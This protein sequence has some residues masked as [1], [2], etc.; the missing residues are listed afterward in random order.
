MKEKFLEKAKTLKI[1][2]GEKYNFCTC[3]RS[4]N[5][6]YCDNEHRK[7]N[8]ERRTNYKSL[9]IIPKSDVEIEVYCSNWD[10]ESSRE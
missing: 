9:K 10:S 5:I 1:I 3:G 6:P 8:E 4:K 7:L 2:A